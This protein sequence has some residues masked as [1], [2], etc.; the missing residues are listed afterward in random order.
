MWNDFT[1]EY[2]T[3]PE[4]ENFFGNY[5]KDKTFIKKGRVEHYLSFDKK[6]LYVDYIWSCSS[7]N[8]IRKYSD[9]LDRD[10]DYNEIEIRPNGYLDFFVHILPKSNYDFN[11]IEYIK[12][13]Y[14]D[15]GVPTFRT[16]GNMLKDLFPNLRILCVHQNW[17]Y[18]G[19]RVSDD[20]LVEDYLYMLELLQLDKFMIKSSYLTNIGNE[21]LFSVLKNN[22]VYIQISEN[23]KTEFC[24]DKLNDKK[25]F[26]FDKYDTFDD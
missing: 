9:D 5:T 12:I 19:S 2:I 24:E 3:V 11:K 15:R 26:I 14:V 18:C 25:I 23:S 4:I 8:T 1:E 21:E 16:F 17:S 10:G 7:I 20:E 22:S 6:F 13:G